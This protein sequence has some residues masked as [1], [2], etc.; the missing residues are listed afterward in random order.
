MKNR[1][2]RDVTAAVVLAGGLSLGGFGGGK[3]AAESLAASCG[4]MAM[5]DDQRMG[6]SAKMSDPNMMGDSAKMD[7]PN[8]MDD[9]VKTVDD[10]AKMGDPNM[11]MGNMAIQ[12]KDGQ[13]LAV[14]TAAIQSAFYGAF[15]EG[16]GTRW[17]QEHEAEMAKMGM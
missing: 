7:D 8:T 5:M 2:F 9:S 6:D 4:D 10:S 16:A 14:Q 15:G 3:A 11:M 13:C 17:V 12:A 1:R